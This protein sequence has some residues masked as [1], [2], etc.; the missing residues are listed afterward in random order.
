MKPRTIRSRASSTSAHANIQKDGTYSVVPR[1][2]GGLTTPNELRAI[3]DAAEKYNV[4]TVKVTGGQRIDLLGVKKEDLPKMWAD[5]NAAGM[6][7]GHAYGKSIR[8]VK[9]CV[10]MP[11]TAASARSCHVDGRQAGKDA[12][13]HVRPAQG[14]ARRFR[15]PAQLCRGRHQGRRHHRRRFRLRDLYRRQRRHQDRSRAVLC[16][17]NSDEEVMEYSGAFL[18]LYRLEGWYLERTCH[19]LERVGMD[20]I[21]GKIL[22]DEEGRK[23]LYAACSTN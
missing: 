10:G 6:V 20:Y 16:K 11:S 14:Q 22:E 8:T 15:L 5:L 9:T 12:V 23:A 1:M 7:S 2:W 18:Q 21:K 3:A 4:P 17:V 13:R 19:Y